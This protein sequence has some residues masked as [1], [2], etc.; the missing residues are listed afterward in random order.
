MKYDLFISY[1]RQDIDFVEPL[2]AAL[3]QAG[4]N[5][6]FDQD[7]DAGADWRGEIV[8]ALDNSKALLILFSRFSNNSTQLIKEVAIADQLNRA[9]IPVLIDNVTPQGAYLYELGTRNWIPLFPNAKKRIPELVEKL[10][11]LLQSDTPYVPGAP[12]PKPGEKELDDFKASTTQARERGGMFPYRFWIDVPLYLLCG[13]GVVFFNRGAFD[14]L[15][16]AFIWGTM[17]GTLPHMLLVAYR[18]GKR[19]HSIFKGLL[20]YLLPLSMILGFALWYDI[21]V[22][23]T[24]GD[25]AV[26]IFFVLLGIELIIALFVHFLMRILFVMRLFR[27]NLRK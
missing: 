24:S 4:I 7:I 16:Y 14:N 19:N 27:R 5:V 1:C 9:V 18:H 25:G 22:Q 8:S 10:L 6:W 2:V 23:G 13:L 11:V 3:K 12:K 21:N 15:L 17:L 26:L 20:S